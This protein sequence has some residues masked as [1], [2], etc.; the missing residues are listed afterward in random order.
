[1]ASHI[2]PLLECVSDPTLEGLRDHI[3]HFDVEAGTDTWWAFQVRLEVFP[4]HITALLAGGATNLPGKVQMQTVMET[5]ILS[6]FLNNDACADN[7]SLYEVR[8]D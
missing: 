8:V 4:E 3:K 7:F 5:G 6:P 2:V 1:M